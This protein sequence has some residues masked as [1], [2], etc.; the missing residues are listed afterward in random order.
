MSRRQALISVKLHEFIYLILIVIF[1][2]AVLFVCWAFVQISHFGIVGTDGTTGTTGR[3]FVTAGT[4]RVGAV[5][6][7]VVT[8]GAAVAVVPVEI[9]AAGVTAVVEEPIEAGARVDESPVEIEPVATEPVEAPDVA[10]EPA[11]EPALDPVADLPLELESEL[12]DAV[13]PDEF[14][15]PEE[16]AAF[17]AAPALAPVDAEPESDFVSVFVLSNSFGGITTG[18]AAG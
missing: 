15:E 14:D 2:F 3:L 18:A 16:P 10:V 6:L 17:L 7:G 11:D 4:A 13:E 1:T 8:V 12:F 5:T 9:A